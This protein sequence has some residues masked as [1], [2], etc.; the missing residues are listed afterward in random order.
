[1]EAHGKDTKSPDDIIEK[2]MRFYFAG[3]HRKAK[4]NELLAIR[5][6]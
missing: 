2:Q 3:T 5:E 6:Q 1:M 4:V